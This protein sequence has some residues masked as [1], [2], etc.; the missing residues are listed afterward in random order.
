MY[1]PSDAVIEN[2]EYVETD[3]WGLEDLSLET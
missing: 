2:S 3:P 1:Q